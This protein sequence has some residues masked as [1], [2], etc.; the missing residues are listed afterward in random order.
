MANQSLTPPQPLALLPLL[1]P[2]HDQAATK[3][4]PRCSYLV[5]KQSALRYV[6]NMFQT[7]NK[8]VPMTPKHVLNTF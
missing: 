1:P 6:S 7:L 2:R 4:R 3:G 5:T 8:Q